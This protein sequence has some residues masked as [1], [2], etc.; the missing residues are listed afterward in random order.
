MTSTIGQAAAAGGDGTA[1]VMAGWISQHPIVDR[2]LA[3]G[4]PAVV[5]L[6]TLILVVFLA[7]TVRALRGS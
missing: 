6:G 3:I 1:Q 7:I 4:V 2:V 5:V